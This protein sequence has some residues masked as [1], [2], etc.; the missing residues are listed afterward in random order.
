M[1]R[2]DY[3][4]RIDEKRV[5]QEVTVMGWVHRVRDMGGLTFLDLRDREGL[6]Q[7][8]FLS[9]FQG[10]AEVKALKSESVVSVHG[11]VVSRETPNPELKTGTVEVQAD[12]FQVLS[13][14]RTSPSTPRTSWNP[15]RRPG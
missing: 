7:I 11:T 3:C 9:T 2:T 13:P 5:G 1:K 6:L 14:V 4:G 10:L 15:P 8:V 12:S